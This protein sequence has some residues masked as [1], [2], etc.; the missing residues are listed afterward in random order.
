MPV[1]KDEARKTYYVQF[2]T[3][4]EKGNR[5]TFKKR[6]FKTKKE[7]MAFERE[8]FSMIS[9]SSQLTIKEMYDTYMADMTQKNK[10]TTLVY[11]KYIFESFILPYLGNQSI[12][13]IT[14]AL[15]FAWQK[16]VL[17]DKNAS[18]TQRAY[19][20]LASLIHYF[21]RYKNLKQNPFEYAK[22]IAKPESTIFNYWTLQDY[23]KFVKWAEKRPYDPYEYMAL[24]GIKILFFTGLRWGELMALTPADIDFD[25]KVITVSKSINRLNELTTPKT[26]YAYRTVSIPNFLVKEIQD[27]LKKLFYT[28]Q[29][30]VFY[31]FRGFAR[32]LLLESSKEISIPYLRIHDLRHSHASLLINLHY[33]PAVIKHRLGH[34]SIQTTMDIYAS[35][36]RS[37]E[38]KLVK[39]LNTILGN[40][41][42]GLVR[43]P[44]IISHSIQEMYISFPD[45][46]EVKPVPVSSPN[47]AYALS[48]E[49]LQGK[50]TDYIK[51]S[52]MLPEPSGQYPVAGMIDKLVFYTTVRIPYLES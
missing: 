14:P 31:Q 8:H 19:M 5:Y 38:Q 4:D 3:R 42:K 35:F 13:K 33:S 25:K 20:E 6:G 45:F 51:K 12:Q 46:P 48:R 9:P 30:L 2:V 43:Y 41:Q 21:R 18:L 23:H 24:V 11:K 17:K 39:V 36:Y 15:L 10:T 7:A 22:C 29:T 50:I 1:Y 37:E 34:K 52:H 26:Q 44:V 27:Y 28:P 40:I 47:E 49:L 32:H 16:E